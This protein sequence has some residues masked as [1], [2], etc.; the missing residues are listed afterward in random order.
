MNSKI[1]VITVVFND[2]ANIRKTMESFFSQTWKDK[3]YIVID[4]G[5][6]DGTVEVIKEFSDKLA[7]WCSEKDEGIYDAM[8]KGI[9]HCV[10]DWINILNSGDF[11]YNKKSLE[12]AITFT[13]INGVDVLYGNSVEIENNSEKM[14]IA[15]SDTSELKKHNIYRHGSSLI[16]TEVQRKFLFDLMK[17]EM[18]GYA[19][20]WDMIYRVFKSGHVFKKVD[21]IIETYQLEGTSNHPIKNVWYNYLVI[22]QGKYN[23]NN[24]I[25]FLVHVSKTLYGMSP[26]YKYLK[27]IGV[28]FIVNDILPYI[29]FWTFRKSYLC[30]LG[31]KIGNHSTFKRRVRFIR[32]WL[33]KIGDNCCID[34]ECVIDA[35]GTI[36]VGNNVLISNNVKIISC[37]NGIQKG[38]PSKLFG[39]II[40]ED[41]VH[42][43][44]GCTILNGVHIGKGSIVKGGAVVVTELQ[45]YGIYAGN[46]AIRVGD[47]PCV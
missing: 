23:I 1:S 28:E 13:D 27:Q 17:E 40:I 14:I 15:S 29:P 26:F 9:A 22:S 7:Y 44:N 6:T 10:G 24:F 18:L 39:K 35:S 31:T 11:Y 8:N 4:G 16:R 41:D 19:L 32:P 37:G 21:V 30:L 45:D 25:R 47:R 46:P 34:N 33:L 3:E 12:N 2:V 43:E 38:R 5:S 42:L 20:D 36:D